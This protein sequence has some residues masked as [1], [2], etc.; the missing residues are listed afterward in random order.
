MGREVARVEGAKELRA[1]LKR[2]GADMKDFTAAHRAVSTLV[3]GRAGPA[4]PRV[5]GRLAGSIRPGGT[6]TQ[7]I[8]RAG[9]V[10]VPYANPIHWG[11][12]ARNI[13][14]SLFLTTTAADTEPEWTDIY[15]ARLEEIIGKVHGA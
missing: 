7:A 12:P 1:S 10:A 15:M 11:W 5:S 2:A 8:A 13:R 6:Q 9:G 4:T 3:A 14:A